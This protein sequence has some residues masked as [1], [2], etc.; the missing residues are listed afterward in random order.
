MT[1][2]GRRETRRR[3]GEEGGTGGGRA[4]SCG[5][6]DRAPLGISGIAVREG[7]PQPRRTRRITKRHEEE[8]FD[9]VAREK[10][11]PHERVLRG[12]VCPPPIAIPAMTSD[13]PAPSPEKFPEKTIVRFT[14]ISYLSVVVRAARWTAGRISDLHHRVEGPFGDSDRTRL[15][16]ETRSTGHRGRGNLRL[17]IRPR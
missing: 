12:R 15:Q 2:D 5:A 16:P 7:L 8:L 11:R 9:V 6:S 3:G 1:R 17:P 10:L 14:T 13:L 4:T